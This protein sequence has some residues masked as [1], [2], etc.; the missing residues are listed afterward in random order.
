MKIVLLGSGHVATQMGKTMVA[1]GDHQIIQVYS[2]TLAHAEA[3]ANVL[4]C[5][6][7]TDLENLVADADLYLLLVTDSSIPDVVSKLPATLSGIVAHSSGATS[8]QV[9][10][11]FKSYA[12]I[13][14][15][16]SFSKEVSINLKEVPFGIEANT[17]EV[18]VKLFSIWSSISNQ[19][20]NCS[21]E[22]RLALHTA[23][24][25]AN[26]FS[27]ALFQ[28]AYDLLEEHQLSFDLLKPII[29]K[30]AEKVQNNIPKEVQTGP[31]IRKDEISMEKHLQF[32]SG[33][34][35]WQLIYQKISDLITKRG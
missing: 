25:F 3:L 34:P 14:P 17:E 7:T 16:Q 26:N 33:H 35:D 8:I 21:T 10:S 27:N 11:K 2:R 30:T 31:A 28:I 6:F 18:S 12:V 13:Y 19:L 29:L 4:H 20:F 9:L 24:V 22:Q 15:V 32:L 1:Q 23:A 5:P